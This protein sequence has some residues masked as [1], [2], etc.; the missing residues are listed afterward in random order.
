M[1][2]TVFPNPWLPY[3][4]VLLQVVITAVFFLWRAFDSLRP[5]L[6]KA[7]PFGDRLTFVGFENFA[8]L[9]TL[10]DD[11]RSIV[12]LGI[13]IS[14]SVIVPMW[15]ERWSHRSAACL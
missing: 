11:H 4:L 12:N 1:K 15:L 9:L 8:R 3:V 7:S 5:S 13:E 10:P 2:R 14:S 6:F